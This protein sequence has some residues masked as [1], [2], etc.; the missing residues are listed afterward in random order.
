[1]D[2]GSPSIKHWLLISSK[3]GTSYDTL[4]FGTSDDKIKLGASNDTSKFDTSNE[5]PKV[6]FGKHF[7]TGAI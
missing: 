1:M 4:K 2:S 5:H 6:F 3:L 7:C